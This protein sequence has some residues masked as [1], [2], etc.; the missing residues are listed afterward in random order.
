MCCSTKQRTLSLIYTT[1]IPGIQWRS[2][3][4]IVTFA[5]FKYFYVT[6]IFGYVWLVAPHPDLVV[7]KSCTMA[8]GGQCVMITSGHWKH[9]E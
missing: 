3:Y 4:L 7:W 1:Y 9:G 5:D 6:Q 8:N 2:M